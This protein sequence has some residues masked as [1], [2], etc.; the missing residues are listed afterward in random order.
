MLISGRQ[1]G[2]YIIDEKLSEIHNLLNNVQPWVPV[3]ELDSRLLH[4]ES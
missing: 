1:K 2:R 4:V 3:V